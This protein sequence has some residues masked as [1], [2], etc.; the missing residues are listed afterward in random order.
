MLQEPCAL[1]FIWNVID[2]TTALLAPNIHRS[3]ID[4]GFNVRCVVLFDHL[5]TGPTILGDLIDIGP[6]DQAQRDIGVP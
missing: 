2:R 6:L 5:D 4:A 3:G 1:I